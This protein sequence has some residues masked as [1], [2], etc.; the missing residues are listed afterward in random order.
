MQ[1]FQPGKVNT[2]SAART[3]E[4]ITGANPPSIQDLYMS[5]VRERAGN[6]TIDPSH[7]ELSLFHLLPSI[8]ATEL[9]TPKRSDTRPTNKGR[10]MG[11]QQTKIVK[12]TEP[13]P[14][15]VQEV[16]RYR[17]EI[18]GFTS[19]HSLGSGTQLLERGW[20][21]H[22]SGVAQGER[23]R[24][25]VGLLHSFPAQPP[26]VGGVLDSAPTGDSIVLLGEFIAHVGN[27]SD[28]WRGV[29]GR[30]GLPDLNPER[31]SVIG[32]L[33]ISH[34]LFMSTN[35]MF[36]HKGVHQ[37]QGCPL[38]PVLFIIFMDRISRRSQGPEGVQFGNH[39]ISSLLFADD[40]VL[41]ASSRPGPS[42][43]TG[44]VCS[45]V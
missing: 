43:C 11:H 1:F 10:N 45:R 42:A 8:D 12:V 34:G 16:E 23:R 26:C 38:S 21:L 41:L 36:E 18:V 13:E 4:K 29:I 25:G 24:A 20:T 33:C 6:I 28:T 30:Y 39:R 3:A 35:T 27:D 40:V 5:R 22:C 15:L 37:H 17:L 2:L 7:P 44:A 31:R 9:C 32:L 14:E 19:M